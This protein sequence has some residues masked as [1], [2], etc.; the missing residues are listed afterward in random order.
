MLMVDRLIA[1][2]E[3]TMIEYFDKLITE[4]LRFERD[5]LLDYMR[6]QQKKSREEEKGKYRSPRA[7]FQPTTPPQR[8]SKCCTQ[9]GW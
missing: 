3:L 2:D 4:N 8:T 7:C 6:E 1:R 5:Q 9:G